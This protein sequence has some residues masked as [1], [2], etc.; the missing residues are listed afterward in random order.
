MNQEEINK[1]PSADVEQ[2]HLVDEILH[3]DIMIA[4]RVLACNCVTAENCICEVTPFQPALTQKEI[5]VIRQVAFG[6]T[7]VKIAATIGATEGTVK[8]HIRNAMHKLRAA[9][10]AQLVAYAFRYGFINVE[11][12]WPEDLMPV[13]P[14]QR[15]VTTV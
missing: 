9:N 8:T 3:E 5:A 13:I 7:N 4:F 14:T 2:G 15:S 6:K 10:H 11:M 1:L 12:L